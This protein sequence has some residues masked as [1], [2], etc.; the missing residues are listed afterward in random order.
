M[1]FMMLL[2]AGKKSESE[3]SA[4]PD[5]K[6]L[7]EMGRFN[8]EMIKAGAMLSGE[9]LRP[10]RDGARV[11]F[12]N[13]KP[14][15]EQGPFTDANLIAGFWIIKVKSKQEAIDWASKVPDPQVADGGNWEIEL[16]QVYETEDF[17]QD[18]EAVKKEKKFRRAQ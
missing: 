16:R 1:R 6:L 13:G 12:S 4:A 14:R 5:E 17:P 15:V 3:T 9:G 18:N 8:E 2:K 11:R 7:N 10:T